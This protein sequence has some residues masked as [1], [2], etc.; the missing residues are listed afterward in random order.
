MYLFSWKGHWA[1]VGLLPPHFFRLNALQHLHGA[2]SSHTV[3]IYLVAQQL[4]VLQWK[5]NKAVFKSFLPALSSPEVT[6]LCWR[7]TLTLRTP[8]WLPSPSLPLRKAGQ[9][10]SFSMSYGR[11]GS[12]PCSTATAHVTLETCFTCLPWLPVPRRWGT[13][14]Q[15]QGQEEL[16][17][18]TQGGQVLQEGAGH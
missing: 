17:R 5:E 11:T 10:P 1:V 2:T 4:Q 13:L 15:R 16:H 9:F 6:V 14:P 3:C 8:P 7:E 12:A 18:G